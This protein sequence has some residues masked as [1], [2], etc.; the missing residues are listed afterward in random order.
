MLPSETKK[1]VYF[2]LHRG[3]AR[4][5]HLSFPLDETS[6]H[7]PD[8]MGLGF[9]IGFIC[10]HLKCVCAMTSNVLAT[11]GSSGLIDVVVCRKYK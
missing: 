1:A 7:V 3:Y 8:L 5:I 4:F 9:F 6:R 2:L 11:S 10:H